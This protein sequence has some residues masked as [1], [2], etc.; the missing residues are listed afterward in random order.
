[1]DKSSFC[2]EKLKARADALSRATTKDSYIQ[3]RCSEY[4]LDNFIDLYF[5]YK[6]NGI[7]DED[8]LK[9][10]NSQAKNI[11]ISFY[12]IKHATSYIPSSHMTEEE[13]PTTTPNMD[14]GLMF[15]RFY[16]KLSAEDRTIILGILAG[17]KLRT[18]ARVLKTT[19]GALKISISRKRK[20][21]EALY[22]QR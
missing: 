17:Y 1:M 16:S 13:Y 9:L 15:N 7:P 20:E 10:I 19:E 2:L 14:G 22:N 5:K 21:W 8:I 6:K 3:G 18:I 4:L 11:L 12:R